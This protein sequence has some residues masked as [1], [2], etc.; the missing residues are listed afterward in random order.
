MLDP[1]TLG[2]A[3]NWELVA[4]SGP[5]RWHASRRW[6]RG[7][8]RATRRGWEDFAAGLPEELA[9]RAVPAVFV[10]GRARADVYVVWCVRGAASGAS[11]SVTFGA[12][13][14]AGRYALDMASGAQGYG[15]T[16][17]TGQK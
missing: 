14:S 11:V 9:R 12:T 16:F 5:C 10:D 13:E 2:T 8:A 1:T 7:C 15:T 4:R 6:S 17:D 3:I